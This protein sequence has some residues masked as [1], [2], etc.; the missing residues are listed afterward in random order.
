M[1]TLVACTS[2]KL[3]DEKDFEVR[4]LTKMKTVSVNDEIEII[5]ELINR[6]NKSF[7]IGH[8]DPLVTV[9]AFNESDKPVFE[10]LVRDNIGLSHKFKSNETYI[11]KEK[12]NVDEKRYIKLDKPGKYK[13]IGNAS[14]IINQNDGNWKEYSLESEPYEILVIE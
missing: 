9:Q 3:P 13:L 2:D 5:S 11:P 10:Y 4:V 12:W 1:L 6:S 14:F 8:S 7:S